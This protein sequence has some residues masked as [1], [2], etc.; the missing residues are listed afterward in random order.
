M[1]T[2]RF[3][4]IFLFCSFLFLTVAQSVTAQTGIDQ[5]EMYTA[6]NKGKFFVYWG[7]NHG[8]YSHSDIHFKGE[9][10]DFT[11]YDAKAHDRQSKF[12]YHNYFQLDRVTIPQTNM[13]IGYF[14][15][16]HYNISLGI[17]HMKYIMT[18]DQIA[19]I[20]GYI[21]VAGDNV[22]N[23]DYHNTPTQLREDFLQFEHTDGLNYVNFEF[24][25]YD[26]LGT[27]LGFGW[28]TDII[29]LNVTE[30]LGIGVLVPKTNT[31]LL[32]RER[33]DEFHF[34]GFGVSAKQGLNITFLKHFFIQGE[35]KE[36][37]IN[38]PNIRTT[39]STSDKASQHFFFIEPTFIF[40]GIFKI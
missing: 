16:D 7:W 19:N 12:S 6:H 5:Q 11:V 18:Q 1:I 23:G 38:M 34:S 36:G 9:D 8:Y 20:K 33:Y 35:L 28:N 22:Y 29:Q 3:Y 10:Y 13:R 32:N 27:L 37:Y 39:N 31:T 4:F 25:R 14:I 21:N 17:D 26:D 40:G 24:S 15:S 30:G 2:K